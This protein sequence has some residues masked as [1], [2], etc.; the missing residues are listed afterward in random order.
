M[1]FSYKEKIFG[2][3][4]VGF[5]APLILTVRRRTRRLPCT[6]HPECV[7][8]ISPYLVVTILRGAPLYGF[9]FIISLSR[10]VGILE[11]KNKT[12]ARERRKELVAPRTR[13][14]T[15]GQVGGWVG[16]G[17]GGYVW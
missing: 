1:R 15:L 8:A 11:A 7:I 17:R 13:V 14:F 6:A 4:T 5:L 10:S 9:I 3:Y 2:T 12:L 16:P